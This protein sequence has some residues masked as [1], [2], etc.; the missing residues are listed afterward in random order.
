MAKIFCFS[1]LLPCYCYLAVLI[2][3]ICRDKGA[4]NV[5]SDVETSD[6][7]TELQTFQKRPRIRRFILILL[8]VGLLGGFVN[9]RGNGI[10]LIKIPFLLLLLRQYCKHISPVKA[11]IKRAE[12]FRFE[13]ANSR[14]VLFNMTLLFA[15]TNKRLLQIWDKI[16]TTF[17]DVPTYSKKVR[18]LSN[19]FFIYIFP[20]W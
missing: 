16:I 9:S 6:S 13:I 4:T 12:D 19:H 7:S 15:F 3:Y 14:I 10:G 5:I 11:S 17:I 20:V 1:T 18:H 2:W 8:M